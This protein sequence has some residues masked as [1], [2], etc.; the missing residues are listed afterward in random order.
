[1]P[2]AIA[3]NGII[4]S[5]VYNVSADARSWTL[6]FMKP[7]AATT[8]ILS[9]RNTNDLPLEISDNEVRQITSFV[10]LAFSMIQ[11]TGFVISILKVS[12]SNIQNTS[13][14]YYCYFSANIP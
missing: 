14:K 11:V 4:D 3:A 5:I 2:N 6:S 12:V 10:Y 13:D 7:L 1:M 9:C 8:I